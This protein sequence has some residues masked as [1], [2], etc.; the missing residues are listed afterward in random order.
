MT[1]ILDGK[2]VSARVRAELKEKAS[3]LGVKPGLATVLV[4][5]D[6]A[7]RMYVGMK[8]RACREAGFHSVRRDLSEDVS[9]EELL[10]VIDG[11]NKDKEVHGILVQLPLP[12]NINVNRVLAA[13]S[14]SKDVDGFH[15]RSMGELMAGDERMVAATPKGVIRLLDEYEIP[16]EGREV[17]IV[18]HSTVVGKPLA[19]LFLNRF[20][21]VTVCHV[22]TEDLGFHTRRADIL[23]PATGVPHLIKED[24]VKEGAV[25]VD[26]GVA[27]KD[28]E[29]VGDVDFEKVKDKCSY[30]SPV[31]GGAGPMTIAML[32][33]N[34]LKAAQAVE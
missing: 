2:A 26:V 8:D 3:K 23:V 25:V 22:K 18:N 19:M 34:T 31:P 21:T 32:L 10:S 33:E 9:E 20:A 11:L 13:V 6:P 1:V 4:G 17:V 5:G 14:H 7:S 12:D 24:M 16:V 15:P 28:S 30:I 27:K 29:T